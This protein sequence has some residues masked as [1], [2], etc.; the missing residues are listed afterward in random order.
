MCQANVKTTAL[1]CIA[2]W[3]VLEQS[4]CW[5]DYSEAEL[6]LSL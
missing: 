6:G 1:S 5:L 2:V 4:D 3:Q